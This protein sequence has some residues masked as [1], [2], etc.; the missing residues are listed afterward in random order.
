MSTNVM[1][2][3]A[4]VTK[5]VREIKDSAATKAEVEELKAKVL[6]DLDKIV[7]AFEEERTRES[8]KRGYHKPG[9]AEELARHGFNGFLGVKGIS[10]FDRHFD[11]KVEDSPEVLSKDAQAALHLIDDVYM[12]DAIMSRSEKGVQYRHD[13]QSMGERDAFLKHFPQLGAQFDALH[14]DL[15]DA[16]KLPMGSGTT[17]GATGVSWIPDGWGTSLIDQLRLATPTVSLFDRFMMPE[18]TFK[19]PLLDS[20]GQAYL[21]TEGVTATESNATTGNV[22][23]TAVDIAHLMTFTDDAA[24]DSIVAMLPMIR[25]AIVRSFSEAYA[26][27]IVNGSTAATHPDNDIHTGAAGLVAKGQDGLR[28]YCQ[29]GT[30]V[31]VNGGGNA[32]ASADVLAARKLMGKYGMG[33]TDVVVLTSTAGYLDLVGDTD[34]KTVDAYGSQATIVTGELGKVYGL[35]IVVD[36][37]VEDRQDAVAD[38]GYNTSG[39]P[40]TF[41]CAV[42]VNRRFWR[43]GDRQTMTFE[44][45]KNIRTGVN[46]MVAVSRAAFREI[47]GE[48]NQADAPHTVLIRNVT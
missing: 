34:V 37:A 27:M 12:V 24:A 11:G 40:N 19:L 47:L 10:R 21:R 44:Q 41:G 8:Q 36:F 33:L 15:V 3:L 17:A 38:T 18:K 43:L 48:T 14:S 23:W 7:K 46:D 30:S 45:D 9:V 13:K 25:A 42:V 32:L 31:D 28:H 6:P 39:G 5:H 22:T 2:K 35:P 29:K 16:I 1:E 4:D 20:I 26:N